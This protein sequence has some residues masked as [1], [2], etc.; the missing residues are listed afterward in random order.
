MVKIVLNQFFPLALSW[1]TLGRLLKKV[2]KPARDLLVP[3][4]LQDRCLLPLAKN[5]KTAKEGPKLEATKSSAIR[6]THNSAVNMK[7]RS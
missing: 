6:L 4:K 3:A 7:G 1:L 2:N 5:V